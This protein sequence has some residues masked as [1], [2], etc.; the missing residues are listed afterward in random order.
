MYKAKNHK[1]MIVIDGYD[2]SGDEK[3][4]VSEDKSEQLILIA[5]D[6][7]MNRAILSE[8]LGHE[9]RILEAENGRECVNMLEQYG[10]G[11]SLI[12]LDIFMPVMDGFEV[13]AYMNKY[14]WIDQIPVIMISS[15]NAASYVERAYDLGVTEYKDDTSESCI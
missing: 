8:M 2:I 12:L 11:I 1:N 7:E 15:E 4:L 9:F 5:D 14:H 10:T 6:S 3:K 13:L